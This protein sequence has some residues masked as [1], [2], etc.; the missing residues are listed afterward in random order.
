M[1]AHR[2]VNIAYEAGRS[3]RAYSRKRLGRAWM[4]KQAW[5]GWVNNYRLASIQIK[6]KT[7]DE[8]LRNRP[9]HC[10]WSLDFER[11]S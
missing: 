5:H 2:I 7:V 6:L 8:R 4:L 11:K 1:C 9:R 3:Q 10:K